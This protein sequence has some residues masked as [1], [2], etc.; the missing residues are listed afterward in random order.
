MDEANDIPRTM[1]WATT[2]PF[3][4]QDNYMLFGANAFPDASLTKLS[5]SSPGSE[6][7]C[8]SQQDDLDIG[9]L[10]T[11]DTG[12]LSRKSSFN[13]SSTALDL[14]HPYGNPFAMN[15]FGQHTP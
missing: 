11:E 3:S 4:M 6:D 15:E 5:P 2:N 8:N 1:P 7:D 13:L 9:N 10:K 14:N 12:S